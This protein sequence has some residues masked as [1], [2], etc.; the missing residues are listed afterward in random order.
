MLLLPA[1]ADPHRVRDALLA[2]L[3]LAAGAVDAL[4]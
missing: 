3:A 4:T 1:T 2:A